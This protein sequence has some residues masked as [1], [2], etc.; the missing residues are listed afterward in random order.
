MKFVHLTPQPQ[1]GRVKRNG[2]RCGNGRRGRGVYA[3][4]MMMLQQVSRTADNRIIRS[5][6]R[7]SLTLWQWL[8][9]ERKRHRNLAAVLFRTAA[10]H[11]P[12]DLYIGVGPSI[13]LDWIKALRST[14]IRVADDEIDLVRDAHEQGRR[15]TLHVS[16]IH[17][18]A[19]GLA[20]WHI[21]QAGFKTWDRY[22]DSIEVVFRS[23]VKAALIDRFV[24]LYRTSKEFKRDRRRQHYTG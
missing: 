16:L 7:S 22:D 15:T 1:I 9:T 8:A 14:D 3:V 11:W 5:E 18:S 20:L 4:P 10:D 17:E 13:G 6:H 19:L 21:Q 24:P 23:P 12:A 2:I